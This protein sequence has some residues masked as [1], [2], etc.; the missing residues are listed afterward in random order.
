MMIHDVGT[1][2]TRIPNG[3]GALPLFDWI[4]SCNYKRRRPE[5][6]ISV[7]GGAVPEYDLKMPLSVHNSN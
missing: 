4:T 3:T 2:N 5:A 7:T 6:R 1:G